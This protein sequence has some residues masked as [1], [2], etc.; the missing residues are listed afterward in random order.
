M[1]GIMSLRRGGKANIKTDD[2]KKVATA[3]YN[4]VKK[5]GKA[6]RARYQD[7]QRESY[8]Q[9]SRQDRFE[10]SQS[11][12]SFL[13]E[14]ED[15]NRKRIVDSASTGNVDKSDFTGYK[16]GLFGLRAGNFKDTGQWI[17]NPETGNKVFIGKA[18]QGLDS[19]QYSD[20]V[21]KNLGRKGSN[22]EAYRAFQDKFGFGEKLGK[23]AQLAVPAPIRWGLGALKNIGKFI[24]KDLKTMAGD[25][26]DVGANALRTA[27]KFGPV[28]DATNMAKDLAGMFGLDG[29]MGKLVNIAGGRDNNQFNEVIKNNQTSMAMRNNLAYNDP[30]GLNNAAFY[31]DKILRDLQ[32]QNSVPD[33]SLIGDFNSQFTDGTDQ[34]GSTEDI[35]RRSVEQIYGEDM[36]VNSFNNSN[37]DAIYNSKDFQRKLNA[38]GDDKQAIE[39]SLLPGQFNFNTN[40]GINLGGDPDEVFED[41]SET[42]YVNPNDVIKQENITTGLSDTPLVDPSGV[43]TDGT[44]YYAAEQPD[45]FDVGSFPKLDIFGN[46]VGGP[47]HHLL[48]QIN[49]YG[50]TPSA[51]EKE[52]F[53]I[54][55]SLG[56]ADGGYMSNFPN[57]NMGT[58]SLTASDNID[59][60]IMKNL[61]FEKMAPGMMGYNQG[62]KVM[63]TFEKLKAIADNN[64]G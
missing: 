44:P 7:D 26:R 34:F 32:R 58:Q 6:A 10:K 19:S 5:A 9:K 27:G 36:D 39:N 29:L 28:K 57:Q 1:N 45:I 17:L 61:Q 43:Y 20:W 12:K 33:S 16:D 18:R 54:L 8:Q 25:F 63:S 62:G 41:V 60:R 53:D 37:I 55:N 21:D 14:M 59:D 30:R 51:S 3:R 24:P 11:D 15:L 56:Q 35:K 38:V 42:E 46:E 4:K 49:K 23:I 48:N 47:R 52:S 40:S 22:S 2:Q 31:E 64:Y 50:N 13:K